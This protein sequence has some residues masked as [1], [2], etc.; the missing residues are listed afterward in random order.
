MPAIWQFQQSGSWYPFEKDWAE[1]AEAAFAAGWITDVASLEDERDPDTRWHMVSTRVNV[2]SGDKESHHIQQRMKK[3]GD[4]WKRDIG[5]DRFVRR[6]N[7]DE[8]MMPP[9]DGASSP[10]ATA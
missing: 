8:D 4:V 10:T 9:P 6:L 7:E 1:T 2:D 3:S 5:R